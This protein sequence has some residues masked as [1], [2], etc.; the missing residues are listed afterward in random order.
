MPEVDGLE[1]TRIIRR[2]LPA[3]RQPVIVAMTAAAMQEDRQ[4]CLAAG[5]NSFVA[6]PIRLEQLTTALEESVNL[7]PPQQRLVSADG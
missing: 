3:E 2:S 4:A 6:K 7:L 1:A 5:M